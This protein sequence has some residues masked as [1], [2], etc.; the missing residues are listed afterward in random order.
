MA[1]FHK[2]TDFDPIACQRALENA[3]SDLS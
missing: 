3:Y 2:K 1:E